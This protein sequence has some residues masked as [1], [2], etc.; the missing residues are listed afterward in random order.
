MSQ[1][2]INVW[3]DKKNIAG[4]VYVTPVYPAG[5]ETGLP[6]YTQP[7]T[8]HF[9]ADVGAPARHMNFALFQQGDDRIKADQ[10]TAMRF[11]G[12]GAFACLCGA[13]ARENLGF[14]IGNST[15]VIFT[16]DGIASHNLTLMAAAVGVET[17]VHDDGFHV[18]GFERNA[19]GHVQFASA[20][21]VSG[22][23]FAGGAT[24]PLVAVSIGANSMYLATSGT[25]LLGFT[26]S[27]TGLLPTINTAM[28]GGAPAS[29]SLSIW[30]AAQVYAG[31][32]T[33]TGPAVLYA[34]G[35][36]ASQDYYQ[37]TDAVVAQN[38]AWGVTA[39]D[40][41]ADVAYD[42]VQG[43]FVAC[44]YSS[45]G[46]QVKFM[47]SSNGAPPWTTSSTAQG[48]S[49]LLIPSGILVGSVAFKICAGVWFL[50]L[51]CTNSSN[52]VYG[53]SGASGKYVTGLYSL[54]FGVTWQAADISMALAS[55]YSS[56]RLRHSHNRFL[57]MH[58]SDVC[59]SGRLGYPEVI[60]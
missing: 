11:L 22:T 40:Q 47:T 36:A 5:L 24:F 16:S 35:T 10:H 26:Y 2:W 51:T 7:G 32:N 44:F 9:T 25:G 33:T 19:A 31:A 46:G 21:T 14:L 3:D 54:D 48:P 28:T 8:A 49:T 18:A 29:S 37:T 58:D 55:S 1:R 43:L 20:S 42:D 15:S 30:S 60:T 13:A 56:L 38:H 12:L 17:V 45:T 34:K 53:S 50:A 27:G 41:L 23:A 4:S 59:I 57:I 52:F 6:V 39:A